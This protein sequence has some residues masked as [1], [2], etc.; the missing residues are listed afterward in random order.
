MAERL[1][2]V[3]PV[4]VANYI[5]ARQSPIERAVTWLATESGWAR[6]KRSAICSGKLCGGFIIVFEQCCPCGY[7][8]YNSLM[9]DLLSLDV[10]WRHVNSLP[11]YK[12][13]HSKLCAKL[14]LFDLLW[15]C[16]TCRDVVDLLYSLLY[17]NLQQI[18]NKSNKWS[19]SL[20]EVWVTASI[21]QMAQLVAVRQ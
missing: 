14:H 13:A 8:A 6:S 11:W 12:Q 18:H 9:R 4:A 3:Q 16:W 5:K 21:H 17:N 7:G 20:T 15:T 1:R 19:F 2:R 10:I